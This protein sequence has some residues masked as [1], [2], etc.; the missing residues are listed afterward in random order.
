MF[1]KGHVVY[2]DLKNYATPKMDDLKGGKLE[3]TNWLDFDVHTYTA[4]LRSI[5]TK[6]NV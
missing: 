4:D 2:F 3:R 6:S 1:W 5:F